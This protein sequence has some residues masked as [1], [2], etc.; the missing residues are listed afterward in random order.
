MTQR[1]LITYTG[2]V[3]VELDDSVFAAV[4]DGWRSQFYNLNSPEEIAQHVG[5]NL[6]NGIPLTHL[7]GFAS[8]T[9]DAARVVRTECFDV[10]V[11]KEG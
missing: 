4:D 2:E 5:L 11:I 1:F 7:D 3:L 9:N 10:R 6:A 8:L